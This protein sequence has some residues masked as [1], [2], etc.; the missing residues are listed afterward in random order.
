[1]KKTLLMIAACGVLTAAQAQTDVAVWSDA[2]TTVDATEDV[3]YKAPVAVAADGSTYVTGNFTQAFAFGT[4][5]LE[6]TANS[7]YLAKYNAAGE[8][9]WAV[10]LKGAATIKAI[11][12]DANGNV[13][14]AGVFADIVEVGS[15]GETETINGMADETEQVSGFIA[16]YNADGQLLKVKTIIPEADADVLASEM[17]WPEGGEVY[18]T[19][20]HL[21]VSGTT[22]YVSAKY[23]GDV[24]VD[25]MKWE[26]EYWI[27]GGFMY[28]DVPSN[29]IMALNAETLDGARSV[30]RVATALP[31][32]EL[33]MVPETL[34]FTVDGDDV[35]VSFIGYGSMKVTTADK[36]ETFDLSYDGA[37]T[38]EHAAFI[39]AIRNGETTI[40]VYHATPHDKSVSWNNIVA[41]QVENDKL[42][43]GGTFN[44]YLGFKPEMTATGSADMFVACVNTADFTVDWVAQSNL[45]E[46]DANQFT[47]TATAMRVRDGKAYITGYTEEFGEHVIQN[48][49]TF[50]VTDAGFKAAAGKLVTG[51]DA[52][53]DLWVLAGVDGLETTYAAYK[54]ADFTAIDNIQASKGI[55]RSG[56]IF[57]LATVGKVR[58]YDMQGRVV[59]ATEPVNTVSVAALPKGVYILSSV[60]G[61]LKFVK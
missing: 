6:N 3:N 30:L 28:S 45:D 2:F 36:E 51:M 32:N 13:Y 7:A 50:N 38:N 42:Y 48:P 26:G 17:Y 23:T 27:I 14:I 37:G 44:G 22:L 12:T 29:G 57:T 18:F 9:Q 47:E 4:T 40:N 52:N 53:S 49:V 59:I 60:D 21:E 24:T 61:V 11:D 8:K 56:D 39:T 1:M 25:G 54:A 15:T 5:F 10:A 19:I 34:N 20:N 33:A 35:Y 55:T 31:F 58:V 43:V 46:G 16:A 41:M